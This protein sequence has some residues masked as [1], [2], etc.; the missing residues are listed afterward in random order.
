MRNVIIEN[1][2]EGRAW[3]GSA[4]DRHMRAW[5]FPSSASSPDPLAIDVAASFLASLNRHRP[6]PD[7]QLSVKH[8]RYTLNL[9]DC[10]IELRTDLFDLA[11]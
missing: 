2:S 3:Y 9:L 11:L 1:Y 8:R 5:I 10:E 6:S 7:R 4:L